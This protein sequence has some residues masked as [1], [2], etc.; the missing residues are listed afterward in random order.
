[1][2]GTGVS[3]GNETERERERG[4]E[5]MFCMIC[6]CHRK[7][8][9]FLIVIADVQHFRSLKI[10]RYINSGD[11]HTQNEYLGMARAV[12]HRNHHVFRSAISLTLTA[13]HCTH[14]SK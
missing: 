5:G 12:L 7:I 3:F 6:D 2:Y 8:A 4:A 13:Q 11:T 14:I 9:F 10:N 1:M